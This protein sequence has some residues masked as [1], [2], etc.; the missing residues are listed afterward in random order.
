MEEEVE[1]IEQVRVEEQVKNTTVVDKSMIKA[2]VAY[3]E[4]LPSNF[5]QSLEYVVK[6]EAL[7]IDYNEFLETKN[8]VPTVD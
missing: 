3:L 4:A 7:V 8:W 6:I 1:E 2:A 5:R